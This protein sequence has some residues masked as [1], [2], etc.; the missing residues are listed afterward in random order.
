MDGDSLVAYRIEVGARTASCLLVGIPLVGGGVPLCSRWSIRTYSWWWVL[1]KQEDEAGWSAVRCLAQM[2][3]S[4]YEKGC[5][6]GCTQKLWR[7]KRE[8]VSF[9][10]E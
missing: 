1:L 10:K 8:M 2:A 9:V 5:Y 7:Q 4:H 6:Q 3:Q